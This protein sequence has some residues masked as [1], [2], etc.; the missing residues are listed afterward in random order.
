MNASDKSETDVEVWKD[1][2]SLRGHYQASSLGQVRSLPRKTTDGR[3]LKLNTTRGGYFMFTPCVNGVISTRSVA[4]VVCEAFHGPKPSWA[5]LV[6]H[7]DGCP[8]N[9]IPANLRWATYQDNESDKRRHGRNAV[10]EK[11]P[12]V[13]LTND[14][15]KDIRARAAVRR[16]GDI[17]RMASEYGVSVSLI[18]QIISGDVWSDEGN[19]K[20][21][22]RRAA[23]K[24]RKALGRSND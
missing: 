7:G 21:R 1:I 6:A 24:A 13:K 5:H 4:Q 3:V 15:V 16:Y 18:N 2:P 9:N 19:Q 14:Q 22:A 10:G 12:S 8:K 23:S 17:K 11:N 20:R